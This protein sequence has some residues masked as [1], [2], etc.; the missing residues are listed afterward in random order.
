MLVKNGEVEHNRII[1]AEGE[2]GIIIHVK[3]YCNFQILG[4]LNFF[5][6]NTSIR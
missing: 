6:S 2:A 4:P 3:C 5:Y 1:D